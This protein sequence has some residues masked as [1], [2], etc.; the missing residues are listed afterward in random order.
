M[1]EQNKPRNSVQPILKIKPPIIVIAL[2]GVGVGIDFAIPVRIFPGAWIQLVAG[3]PFI[4]GGLVFG[5]AAVMAFH[6][7]GTDDRFSSPT[8]QIVQHGVLKVSRN[9]M[10]VGMMLI[11]LGAMLMVNSAWSL[12]VLP[13]QFAYLRY[14]VI[15]REE[16]YLGQWFG[17]EYRT[18]QSKV[19]RWI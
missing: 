1:T 10:Y 12:L 6:R 14:G 18:Y 13:V 16:E 5:A 11:T 2:I 9:P 3:L 17:E 15:L 4:V 7:V 8:T 19:R